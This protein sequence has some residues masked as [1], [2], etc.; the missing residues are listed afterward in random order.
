MRTFRDLKV[1][2]KS[3]NLVMTIYSITK[4]LPKEER[5]VLMTQIRRAAMSIPLNI[6]EGYGKSESKSEYKRFLSI[7]KGSCN[8]MQVL[9]DL[10]KALKYIDEKLH[11]E[12]S[13]SYDEIGK[14]LYGLMKTL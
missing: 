2:Q 11:M 9:V 1:Y 12:L 7:A 6:A 8:E 3:F 13:N 14:M 10:L 5:Y 4:N